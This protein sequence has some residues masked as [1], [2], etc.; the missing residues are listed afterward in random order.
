MKSVVV[1]HVIKLSFYNNLIAY[2]KQSSSTYS[3]DKQTFSTSSSACQIEQ[4]KEK[5]KEKDDLINDLKLI[6]QRNEEHISKMEKELKDKPLISAE[7]LSIEIAKKLPML[8][9][10]QLALMTKEKKK[11]NWN[12]D[13]IATGFAHSY[14]GKSG[15]N[16]TI[17]NLKVPEPSIRTLQK[18]GEKLVIEPGILKGCFVVLEALRRTLREGESQ[19]RRL[20][21]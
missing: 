3:R 8:T 11:V 21:F 9:A 20:Y 13:E 5:L 19:V 6:V 1:L 16:F 12:A 2:R 7:Q 17:H 18:W 14:L 15:Y 10:N 4:L